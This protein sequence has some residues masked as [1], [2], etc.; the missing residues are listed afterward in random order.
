MQH[1]PRRARD[2]PLGAVQRV[3]H[4]RVAERIEMDSDLMPAPGDG[5]D[6]E[7]RGSLETLANFIARQRG[8]APRADPHPPRAEGPDRLVDRSILRRLPQDQGQ[9]RFMNFAALELAAENAMGPGI[10]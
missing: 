5:L 2:G 7:Q 10:F 8:L 3:P 9:V 4:D 1:E 6:L